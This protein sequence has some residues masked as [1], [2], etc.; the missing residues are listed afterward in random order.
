MRYYVGY[1]AGYRN[2]E[3]KIFTRVRIG[4]LV[5]DVHHTAFFVAYSK[6]W[7]EDED[8]KPIRMEYFYVSEKLLQEKPEI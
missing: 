7:Y 8:I 2:A 4:Y 3:S 1:E 5:V 6:G